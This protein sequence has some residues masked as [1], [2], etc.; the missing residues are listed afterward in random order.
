MFNPSDWNPECIDDEVLPDED[1]EWTFVQA[2][3]MNEAKPYND[4]IGF[5]DE[6]EN[7]VPRDDEEG[8]GGEAEQP[9]EAEDK[10]EE[11]HVHDEASTI[12]E[13]APVV[14]PRDSVVHED[15]Y[16]ELVGTVAID[17]GKRKP[18]RR[19]SLSNILEK[20]YTQ[21]RRRCSFSSVCFYPMGNAMDDAVAYVN[22]GMDALTAADD[23]A[24]KAEL[25]AA[26]KAEE[27]R[28]L[29]QVD[30]VELSRPK[31]AEHAYLERRKSTLDVG[32][33]EKAAKEVEKAALLYPWHAGM[34]GNDTGNYVLELDPDETQLM[35]Q[36]GDAGPESILKRV[37]KFIEPNAKDV[38]GQANYAE[39]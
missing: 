33:V 1:G 34:N 35:I 27:D 7:I 29:E 23:E 15:A 19:K 13:E 32:K 26:R 8:A 18:Q 25:A 17:D 5:D 36:C 31:L 28:A 4:G 24:K 20:Q 2:G 14:V 30:E 11:V 3:E 37:N 9:V 6:G 39:V 21:Q 10:T 16:T 22:K 12:P 38:H